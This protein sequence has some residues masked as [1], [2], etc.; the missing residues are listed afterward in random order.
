[1]PQ[2]SLADIIDQRC[3]S[4]ACYIEP[5]DD[6]PIRAID[7][8]GRSRPSIISQLVSTVAGTTTAE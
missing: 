5:T 1:V 6:E 7:V 3:I 4:T 8:Y 2:L